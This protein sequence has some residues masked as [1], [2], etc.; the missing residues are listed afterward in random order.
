MHD[1]IDNNDDRTLFDYDHVDCARCGHHHDRVHFD[2]RRT[3]HYPTTD[4]HDDDPNDDLNRTI[5]I[6][7]H[8]DHRAAAHDILHRGNV[9]HFHFGAHGYDVYGRSAAAIG[10]TH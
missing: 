2:D 10:H 3:Y 4:N 9:Y 7:Y 5:R 8:G 1:A 6:D